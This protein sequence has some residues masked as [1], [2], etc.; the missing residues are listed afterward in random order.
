M[1]TTAVSLALML[2][3]AGSPLYATEVR[4]EVDGTAAR[5]SGFNLAQTRQQR[6]QRQQREPRTQRQATPQRGGER[7]AYSHLTAWVGSETLEENDHTLEADVW[8]LDGALAS[9]NTSFLYGSWQEA[10]YGELGQRTV[11]E[12]G[13]GVH[14]HYTSRSSFFLNLGYVQDRWEEGAF[15]RDSAD[16]L[17]GRY[18]LRGKLTD[19][20]EI[21]GA[22]VY[23]RGSGSTDMESRWSTDVGLSIYLT[24]NFALRA[25][26]LD[27]EGI[28]PTTSFGLRLNFGN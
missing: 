22:I 18:G 6:Q 11:R 20:I 27:L 28:H 19:R 10:D 25:A 24:D 16:M 13:F 1:N 12:I 2:T 14:E 23:T 26:G 4:L 15:N 5:E 21:D 17:R 9:G 7:F 8:R 3:L